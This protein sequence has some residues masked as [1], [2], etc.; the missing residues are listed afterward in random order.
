MG[1]GVG[2]FGSCFSLSRNLFLQKVVES[3]RSQQISS[4]LRPQFSG[5]FLSFDGG[6]LRVAILCKMECRR[7]AL[8]AQPVQFHEFSDGLAGFDS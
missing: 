3:R 6:E 7:A 5:N 8:H 4:K 2:D 1:H